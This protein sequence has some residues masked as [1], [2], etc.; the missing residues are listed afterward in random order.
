[1]M[2]KI[3]VP[4]ISA[5]VRFMSKNA[6]VADAIYFGNLQVSTEII[7]LTKTVHDRAD[8][9]V[10]NILKGLASQVDRGTRGLVRIHWG[11]RLRVGSWGVWA[12]IYNAASGPKKRLGGIYLMVGH[13]EWAPE[14]V[15]GCVNPAKGGRDGIRNFSKLCKTKFSDVELAT[16]KYGWRQ[17]DETVVWFEKR[18]TRKTSIQELHREIELKAKRFFKVAKPLLKQMLDGRG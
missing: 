2:K 17:S 1:M 15:V 4:A 9:E 16:T 7:E 13:G 11:N 18:L 6:E 14:K 5:E 12:P 8:I 3:P 10:S